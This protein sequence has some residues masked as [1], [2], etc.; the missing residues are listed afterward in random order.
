[1]DTHQEGVSQIVKECSNDNVKKAL[2][3]ISPSILGGYVSLF[4]PYMAGIHCLQGDKT[5]NIQFVLVHVLKIK[6]NLHELSK[7][8]GLFGQ[9]GKCINVQ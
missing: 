8:Q 4:E 6:K 5:P 3:A 9:A 2:E 7:N 1:M